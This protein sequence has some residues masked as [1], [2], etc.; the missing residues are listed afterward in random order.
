M[1]PFKN[2]DSLNAKG[3][4]LSQL[5]DNAS[6]D[7]QIFCDASEV[8]FGGHLTLDSTDES[9]TNEVSG[10]WSNTES[11]QSSTWRELEAVDRVLKSSVD[12]T[13]GKSVKIYTDNKNVSQMLKVGSRKTYLQQKA[14]SVLNTC[15]DYSVVMSCDWIPRE[16]NMKADLLSRQ[17]DCDDWGI[18]HWVYAYLS[19]LWGNFTFDRF[20]SDYNT[21]CDRF[22]SKFYCVGTSGIDA[23]KYNWSGENN[24]LVPPPTLIPKV[25]NKLK[26]EK[27]EGTLVIPEWK[28]APYWCMLTHNSKFS[29][30]VKDCRY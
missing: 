10:S 7:V 16:E 20:V 18:E 4:K 30:F 6:F 2:I 24:W 1:F 26:R 22:N 19:K 14:L 25:I 3:S 17:S 27:C 11:L 28:S 15:R 5:T 9:G 8:G 12:R 29:E 23:F 13:K 21:K